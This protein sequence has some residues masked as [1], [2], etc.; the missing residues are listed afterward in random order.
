MTTV[1]NPEENRWVAH[2]GKQDDS[3][4]IVEVHMSLET[5]KKITDRETQR[6]AALNPGRKDLD[7]QSPGS[8]V[9]SVLGQF[10]T[11]GSL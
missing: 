9:L 6:V 3:Q 10:A 2:M 1:H 5:A 11:G 7:P 8:A 4:V